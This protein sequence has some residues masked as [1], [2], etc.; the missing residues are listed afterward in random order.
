MELVDKDYFLGQ[1]LTA[2]DVQLLFP[3]QGLQVAGVLNDSFPRLTQWLA[4]LKEREAYK[5][6]AAKYPEPN[7]QIFL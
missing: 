5:A 2:C 1:E 6:T 7:M 3:L 4:R